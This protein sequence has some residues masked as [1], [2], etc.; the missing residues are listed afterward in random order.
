MK[1]R[2]VLI[3]PF[4]K[5]PPNSLLILNQFNSQSLRSGFETSTC[6]ITL[7]LSFNV[8]VLFCIHNINI[9][10]NVQCASLFG[11]IFICWSI[12][13]SLLLHTPLLVVS[14]V[15]V[16]FACVI[17]LGAR[18]L[19]NNFEQIEVL[20]VLCTSFFGTSFEGILKDDNHACV[21]FWY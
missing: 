8:F 21:R 3:I 16:R 2:T 4:L 17:Y 14:I 9:S 1:E 15:C 12:P 19:H 10:G 6:S 20:P 18:N 13:S 11:F 5:Q 7:Y